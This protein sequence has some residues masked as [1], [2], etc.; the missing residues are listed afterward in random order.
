MITGKK[1]GKTSIRKEN[2]MNQLINIKNQDGKL[3]VS[4]R[5]IAENFGKEHKHVLETVRNITAEN[6]T[7]IENY[8]IESSYKAGTGKNYREYQL[9]RDG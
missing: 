4:S 7:L 9:T 6:P 5:E 3:T 2:E 1:M 8:F